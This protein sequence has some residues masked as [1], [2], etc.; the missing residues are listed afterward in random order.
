M[1]TSGPGSISQHFGSLRDP[2]IERKKL[3]PL[4]NILVIALC[5]IICGANDWVE[6]EAFGKAK[7]EWLSKHL[8]LRHGIPSHD[9]FGRVFA[10]LD[11]EG[12]QQGFLSWMQAVSRLTG[13]QVIA[14]DGKQLCGSGSLGQKAITMVSAFA[15]ENHL[16]LAQTKVDAKSNEI[17]ALPKLLELLEIA[18]CIITID[19]MGCQT[20]IASQIV[21][22][23]A[24]YVLTLKA[25]QGRLYEDASF[26]FAEA[27]RTQFAG[28][29]HDYHKTVEKGHGR[30]ECRECWALDPH[31]WP[32]RFRTLADWAG[33]QAI[34][35]I[36]S[37]RHILAT[38]KTEVN[39]SYHI[40]SLAPIAKSILTAKR[41]HWGIENTLHWSL[42]ISFAEDGSRVR[43][44]AAPAN[45]ATLRH[46]ALNLLKHE[47]SAKASIKTK[48]LKCAWDDDYLLK[49]LQVSFHST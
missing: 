4:I 3:H 24:D 33:L 37:E 35:C 23:E 39:T 1:R 49:V 6:I 18:G 11:P 12:F 27:R 10:R 19:A 48:R 26:F 5:G 17:T 20:E 45:L 29:T 8:N 44:G 2:R 15:T 22:K 36:R 9:T 41:S 21:G 30:I 14:L 31:M 34:A 42:D 32:E 43:I 47:K 38:G 16:V 25:N 40:T 28:I 13:G 7:R 46:I